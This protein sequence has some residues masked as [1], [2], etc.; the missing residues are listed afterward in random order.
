MYM[1]NYVINSL[2]K[3]TEGPSSNPIRTLSIHLAASVYNL[4][5]WSLNHEK[6]KRSYFSH[7]KK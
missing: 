1:I 4:S 2:E 3:K 6:N 7:F 5:T